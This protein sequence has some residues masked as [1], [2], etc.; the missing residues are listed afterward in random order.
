MLCDRVGILI[1]GKLL[2]VGVLNQILSESFEDIELAIKNLNQ[3]ALAQLQRNSRKT[4]IAE[5]K[6]IFYVN[7]EEEAHFLLEKA[8]AAGGKLVSFVPRRKTL[9]DHFIREVA[10]EENKVVAPTPTKR[11]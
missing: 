10:K 2:T 5:D 7:S 1:N 6:V 11:K 3:N 9:E 4:F 8:K